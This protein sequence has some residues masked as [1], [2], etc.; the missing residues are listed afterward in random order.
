LPT[1]TKSIALSISNR[2]TTSASRSSAKK[3]LKEWKRAWK[4]SLIERDNPDW[5]DLYEELNR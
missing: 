1:N 5:R 2:T 4:V 3:T